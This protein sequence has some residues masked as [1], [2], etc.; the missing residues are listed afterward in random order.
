MLR[1]ALLLT[2]ALLFGAC[3]ASRSPLAARELIH[4]YHSRIVV[5]QDGSM[6]VTERITVTA[7]GDK[8]KRGIY[9]D[10][11][12]VYQGPAWTRVERP[13][14]VTRV[15]RD[16]RA[17]PYH[18]ER[19]A[20]SLRI[21]IG[22]E[23]QLIS[24]GKHTFEITYEADGFLGYFDDHDELY[25]NVTGNDWDF[26]VER[27][28]ADVFLPAAVP[29]ARITTEGY[30]GAKGSK[31][32]NLTSSID[33]QT[34]A[35]HF[36]TT[37]ELGRHEGLTIVV[38]FPKNLIAE[39]TAAERRSW[40]WSAN[41]ML[42]VGGAG[43]A[44]VLLYYLVVWYRLGRD[45]RQGTIFPQFEP[46]LD[47]PPA[48]MRFVREMGF[49]K[50]CFAA[51]LINMAVKGAVQIEEKN[52]RYTLRKNMQTKI[53]RSRKSRKKKRKK[54]RVKN[55]NI[56][57]L[58]PGEKAAARHLLSSESLVLEV[59]NHK[60]VGAAVKSLR[61]HLNAEFAGELFFANRRWLIPGLALSLLTLLAAGLSESSGRATT[62]LIVTTFLSIWSYAVFQMVLKVIA[63]W[64][65]VQG[66]GDIL[67]KLGSVGVA[68]V[69]VLM[70]IPFLSAEITLLALVVKA[71]S[72]YVVPLFL[73]LV[74]INFLFLHLLKRPTGRGRRVMDDIE[75]FRMYLMAAEALPLA[76][77]HPPQR[78]AE[79]FEEYLP[80]ALALDVE[81]EWAEQFSGVLHRVGEDPGNGSYHFTW[82][83]GD[84][85]STGQL[86]DFVSG[87][88]SSLGDAISSSAMAPGSSSGGGGG[89]SSGGGGGGGG[90]G[91]W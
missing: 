62:F 88:G 66:L 11:P 44:L 86:G 22:E 43:G 71:T 49:D 64:R 10:F 9:R 32:T 79:L 29:R 75:G 15:R 52:G 83:S 54:R 26:A 17:E 13:F 56:V 65:Y 67:S 68:I 23:G 84:G 59:T 76:Q 63:A 40:M 70:L 33:P 61:K 5:H 12:T 48:C 7:E 2:V 82:H 58:S 60:Q 57:S 19:R 14:R 37:R 30:T 89:G 21:Y 50:K 87:L 77:A 85:F 90:G 47:L 20:D 27:A 41:Q 25:W 74:G 3:V 8:I 4:D 72:I 28:S 51:A 55:W 1:T 38:G 81:N 45:P 18:T 46:P 36:E 42:I 31:A 24:H 91:G 39:P 73:V 69:G 34:G 35:A 80:Y 16:G 78:T 53:V 6:T